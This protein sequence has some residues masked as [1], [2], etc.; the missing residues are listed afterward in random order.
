MKVARGSNVASRFTNANDADESSRAVRPGA[1]KADES[2]GANA[3][4]SESTARGPF[5]VRERKSAT[6]AVVVS[7]EGATL[8]RRG[9]AEGAKSPASEAA[10]I[11]VFV[12]RE[13]RA[14]S[15]SEETPRT[16][17]YA[18]EIP[19][20]VSPHESATLRV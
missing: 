14:A 11:K 19:A 3:L 18:R 1:L 13:T 17:A 20:S 16:L 5:G 7:E 12:A 15:V 8:R 2:P 4:P 6:G 10:G 9:A